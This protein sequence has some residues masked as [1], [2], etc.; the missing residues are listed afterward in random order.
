[1]MYAAGMRRSRNRCPMASASGAG[2]DESVTSTIPPDAS[3]GPMSVSAV[4][5]PS[6]RN[7]VS[8][9]SSWSLTDRSPND[10]RS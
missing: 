9:I 2:K 3:A 10:V 4:P 5:L 6:A 8:S 7:C 1:M